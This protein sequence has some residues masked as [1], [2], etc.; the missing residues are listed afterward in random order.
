MNITADFLVQNIGQLVS[1]AAGACDALGIAAGAALASQQGRIVWIGADADWPQRV[2][3]AADATVLDAQGCLVTPGFVDSHTHIVYAGQRAAEFHERLSGV[4]YASQLNQG[5]GI[6]STV[7]AT[8]AASTDELAASARARLQACMRHGSTTVEVKTGYGLDLE[9]EAR[10]L[11]VIE[12]LQGPGPRVVPTFMGAHLV[13]AEHRADRA[14]YM[15]LLIDTMLPAFAGRARFC[16][17]FCEQ[18]AFSVAE[19]R[20][21][22]EHARAL[23]YRLKLHAN[24]LGASGG[25]ALA[26]EL[27]AV[28]ADHLDFTGPQELAALAASGVVATLLPGCSMTLRSAYPSARPFLEAGVHLALAT[29]YNP[30]TCACE[31]MQL[32]IALAVLQMD[33]TIEQALR[34]ATL[35]GAQALAMQREVGS[36][37]VGKYADLLLWDAE[38]Y[39]ELGYRLGTNLVRAV[40]VGGQ[41]LYKNEAF[42]A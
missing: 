24:Q 16:D 28:S 9:S 15:R 36:L 29:D 25:A 22:L 5:R 10:S 38:S 39:L 41:P 8:R 13:P 37:E 3:L 12:R 31:N 30:G 2:A 19:S 32:M 33:C 4:T 42:L 1:V 35:G 18:G 23:G 17:V 7:A 6:L 26:A 27:G 11:A 21:L 14:A 20:A 34:A 40:V